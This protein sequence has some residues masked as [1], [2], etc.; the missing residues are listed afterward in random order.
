MGRLLAHIRAHTIE[1]S[2]TEPLQEQ[3]KWLVPFFSPAP[4]HKHIANCG[5]QYSSDTHYLNCLHQTPPHHAPVKLP[6]PVMSQSHYSGSPHPPPPPPQKTS[7]SP[8]KHCI[9]QCRH[10]SFCSGGDRS[11]FTN[12]SEHT[13]LKHATFRPRIKHCPQQQREPLQTT[14]V[15][16]KGRKHTKKAKMSMSIKNQSRNS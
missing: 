10:L 4:L 12:I 16:E 7:P 15:K 1:C 3:R 8:C 9:S 6:F 2:W 14:G 13:Q 5:N 11:H